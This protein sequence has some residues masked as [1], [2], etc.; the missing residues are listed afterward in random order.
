M[1]ILASASPRRKQLL[2]EIC[3]SFLIYPA[4]IDEE[5]Y[6]KE[7]VSY[8]KAVVIGDKYPDDIIISADTI[9][10]LDNII[11]GKPINEQDAYRILKILSNK[12]HQ[13]ITYYTIYC[14]NKKINIS[15]ECITHVTFN[16]LSD[17]LIN[18][19]IK[20]KSPLDK[21]GA[22]GYQDNEKYH[23]VKDIV[24]SKTNVIGFPIEEI[25]QE[26]INLKI[27]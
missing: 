13:V 21:A 14:K 6:P 7:E 24:G 20:S 23:L 10:I 26:L 17:E 11:F 16:P 8:Q 1:I 18:A 5:A 3:P 12:T 9:V 15:K 19:Y 4:N 2:N 25:K 27:I 22:Y